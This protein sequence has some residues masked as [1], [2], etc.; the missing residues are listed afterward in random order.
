MNIPKYLPGPS[1]SIIAA[2]LAVLQGCSGAVTTAERL[3]A[4]G[5][6][7]KFQVV[8]FP[9]SN[10]PGDNNLCGTINGI[11]G[12]NDLLVYATQDGRVSVTHNHLSVTLGGKQ[13]WARYGSQ[14]KGHPAT[15]TEVTLAY[16]VA[17]AADNFCLT[18]MTPSPDGKTWQNAAGEVGETKYLV[19]H[20]D[21]LDP[22]MD[23]VARIDT[24]R[25]RL[26]SKPTPQ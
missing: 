17:L 14:D 3:A 2:S 22:L 7:D 26:Q 21:P 13:P 9:N 25:D 6:L 23:P 5:S 19:A 18:H 24:L 8:S 16:G 12:A 1:A 15:S 10:G 4:P 11:V 20:F